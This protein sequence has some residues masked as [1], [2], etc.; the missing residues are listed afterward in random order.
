MATQHI[1]DTKAEKASGKQSLESK[2]KPSLFYHILD[3]DMPESETSVERLSREAM[4][5]LGGGSVSTARTLDFICYYVLADSNIHAR[6]Q[7]DLQDVMKD[8]PTI[9]P[10]CAQLEKRPYLQ[11]VIKE[12]LRCVHSVEATVRISI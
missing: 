9:V 3:S 7:E 6:L 5:L 1:T 12:G 2:G 8:Y 11:A 4:V 10:S